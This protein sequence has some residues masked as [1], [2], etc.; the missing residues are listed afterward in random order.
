MPGHPNL[1]VRKEERMQQVSS[2]GCKS[3]NSPQ[4][5]RSLHTA[6]DPM[7]SQV[8]EGQVINGRTYDQDGQ[9][10]LSLAKSAVL[11]HGC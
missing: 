3:E 4:G 10:S 8:E 7:P 6:R 9:A 11:G 5:Q 2:P 1:E